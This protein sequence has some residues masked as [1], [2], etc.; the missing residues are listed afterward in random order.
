MRLSFEARA[1]ASL[2]SRPSSAQFDYFGNHQGSLSLMI[3]FVLKD[4]VV[5]LT[6]PG[7]LKNVATPIVRKQLR[8]RRTS[9][10]TTLT[11]RS[12]DQLE[13]DVD[14]PGIHICGSEDCPSLVLRNTKELRKEARSM[15]TWLR[16]GKRSMENQLE[17]LRAN[18]QA[19]REVRSVR[20]GLEGLGGR[21]HK[22][23]ASLDAVNFSAFRSAFLNVVLALF[24]VT[25][26]EMLRLCYG[27]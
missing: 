3:L 25:V 14:K 17:E 8:M 11:S 6:N 9:D 19:M 26:E 13:K 20:A 22:A 2:G 15:A 5:E 10:R 1:F 24:G 16:D 7:E 27:A 21:V 23:R 12:L 4:L 18:F